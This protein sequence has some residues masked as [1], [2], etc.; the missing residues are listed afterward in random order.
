MMALLWSS[1]SLISLHRRLWQ[2][3]ETELHPWWRFAMHHYNEAQAAR[4]TP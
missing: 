1:E 3:G 4:Q 2:A